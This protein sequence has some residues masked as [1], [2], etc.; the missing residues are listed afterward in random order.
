MTRRQHA[1]LS[2][3]FVQFQQE[4]Q[5]GGRTARKGSQA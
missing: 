1:E 5:K 4:R 3:R 2:E